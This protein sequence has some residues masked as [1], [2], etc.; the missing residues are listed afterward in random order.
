MRDRE[1]ESKRGR[2][3]ERENK[4][5][6]RYCIVISYKLPPKKLDVSNFL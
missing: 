4:I 6:I 1:R 3:R 5:I 2:E